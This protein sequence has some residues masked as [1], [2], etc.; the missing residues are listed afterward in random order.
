MIKKIEVKNVDGK[1]VYQK[2]ETADN[3]ISKKIEGVTIDELI[4]LLIS[5]GVI[6]QDKLNTLL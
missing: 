1:K 2:V 3:G 4:S 6:T 5:E